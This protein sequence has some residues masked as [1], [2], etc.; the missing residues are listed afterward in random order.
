MVFVKHVHLN[1]FKE[2]L[3]FCSHL[4]KT[5]MA[6]NVFEKLSFFKSEIFLWENLCGCCTDRALTILGTKCGFQAFV[7]KQNSNTKD[8]HCMVHCH[9]ITSKT[10]PPLCLVLDQTIRMV[11]FVK[12][13]ALNSRL[14]K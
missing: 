1:S 10:R 5:T 14:F 3:L 9:A 12:G 13:G 6:V 11:N 8:V 4:E 2:E 7:K